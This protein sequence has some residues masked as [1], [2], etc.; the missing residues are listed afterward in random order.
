M[1]QTIKRVNKS[2]K[3]S[4]I[5]DLRRDIKSKQT[6]NLEKHR[7]SVYNMIDQDDE[8]DDEYPWIGPIDED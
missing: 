4:E 1:A 7:N 2:R 3:D 8:Y 5:V 6:K